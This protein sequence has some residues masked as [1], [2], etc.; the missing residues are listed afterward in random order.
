VNTWWAIYMPMCPKAIVAMLACAR[1]WRHAQRRVFAG[2]SAT[3]L[4][5]RIEDAEAKL[6]I[7]TM[8]SSA[9]AR[10]GR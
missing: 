5:A 2:F 8:G 6:V 9:A 10:R 7:T 1:A 3:A 4:K